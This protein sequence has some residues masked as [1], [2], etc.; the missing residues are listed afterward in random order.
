MYYIASAVKTRTL[1]ETI[2]LPKYVAGDCTLRKKEILC[3]AVAVK[4]LQWGIRDDIDLI[5]IQEYFAS[6]LCM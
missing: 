2:R 1:A 5:N 6:Y 3:A 4:I